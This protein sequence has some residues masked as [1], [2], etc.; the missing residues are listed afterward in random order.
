MCLIS[1]RV[2]LRT[3]SG[4]PLVC[5]GFSGTNSWRAANCGTLWT[6]LNKGEQV[7]ALRSAGDECVFTFYLLDPINSFGHVTCRE[8][9]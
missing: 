3:T 1:N 7:R 6:V 2:T 5:S 9:A 8:R 4:A